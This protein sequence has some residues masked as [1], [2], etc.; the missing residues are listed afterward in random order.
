MME[1]TRV[2][3]V[4]PLFWGMVYS[5]SPEGYVDPTMPSLVHFS[6]VVLTGSV[7]RT[8]PDSRWDSAYTIEVKVSCLYKKTKSDVPPLVNITEA[9]KILK[10]LTL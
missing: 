3:V 7:V 1:L 4:L 8:F 5:C 10:L 9:G 2:L 6:D